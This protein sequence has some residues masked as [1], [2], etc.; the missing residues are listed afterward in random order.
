MI[1]E[2]SLFIFAFFLLWVGSGLAVSSVNK[3]SHSLRTSSFFMS[4]F[5]LG[6]FASIT[7]IMVGINAVLENEP[8]IYVGNLIGG[9]VVI[10]LMIIP[11]LAILGGGVK[12]THSFGFSTLVS[13]IFAIGFPAILTLD[14]RIGTIDA[15]ICVVI[16]AYSIYLLTKG[17]GFV[18]KIVHV[19]ATQKTIVTSLFKII[20][21]VILVFSASRILVDQTAF[22]GEAL[23]ISPFIISIILISIGTNIPELSIALRSIL[24]RHKEVALGTYI[25]S[26]T[27]NI[28]LLGVLSLFGDT[29]INAD[30][31]NYSVLMY[32]AG[33]S[34]FVYFVRSK[35]ELSRQEGIIL[36]GCYLFF[37]TFELLTGPGWV[38]V[39]N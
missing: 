17:S 3:I 31:S 8:E 38:F 5:V 35:N 37:V 29:P 6:L 7:E 14:N 2:I 22:F 15:I 16:Y 21:A 18:N 32:L 9:C 10:V 26:A 30:G 13:S 33:L 28:L 39:K 27:F 19:Q 20:I 24:S 23:N 4:F 11:L 25:G 34:L 36:L 12:L 1:T